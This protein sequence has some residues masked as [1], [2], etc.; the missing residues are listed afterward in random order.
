MENSEKS[1]ESN[2]RKIEMD[3]EQKEDNNSFSNNIN[4]DEI[5]NQKNKNLFIYIQKYQKEIILSLIALIIIIISLIILFIYFESD[6]NICKED[7]KCSLCD[8]NKYKCIKCVSGFKLTNGNCIIN[9]SFKAIYKS[10]KVND[11]VKLF[12][13]LTYDIIEI[14]VNDTIVKPSINYTFPSE[15]NY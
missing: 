8:E 4:N 10:N 14:I 13:N 12:N 6:L 7:E 11:T 5:F 3:I 9:Y 2:N 1:K 15:G